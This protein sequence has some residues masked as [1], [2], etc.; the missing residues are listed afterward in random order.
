MLNLLIHYG[1]NSFLSYRISILFLEIVL[2]CCA[3]IAKWLLSVEAV[4]DDDDEKSK[5]RPMDD[6]NIDGNIG[7][8]E[9]FFPHT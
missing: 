7:A 9:T 1:I 4:S 5:Q 8:N 2:I 6:A 3:Y